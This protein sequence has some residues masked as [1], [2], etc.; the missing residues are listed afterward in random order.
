M[1][2]DGHVGLLRCVVGT[3][4]VPPPRALWYKNR[5]SE[6][7][8]WSVDRVRHAALPLVLATD[9]SDALVF[10]GFV[11]PTGGGDEALARFA[12]KHDARL[13]DAADTTRAGRQLG[14]YLEGRRR[15]FDL[16]IRLLGTDFQR[17]VWSALL[18]IPYG[19]IRSYAQQAESIGRPEAVRAVGKANGDNP[20]PVVIPCHRVLGK[21]GAL[22]GFG[23]GID[24]KR[25]LLAL[26]RRPHQ[27]PEWNPSL[28]SPRHAGEQVGLSL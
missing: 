21:D 14:E 4:H 12:S 9:E 5:V 19:E 20:V 15:S 23:G 10:V 18:E 27:P 26:E 17:E 22:T 1:G 13:V 8:T 11:G 25:W 7:A 28:D 3:R 24:V 16:P 2:A 6:M